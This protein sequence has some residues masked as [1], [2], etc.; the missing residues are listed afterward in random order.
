MRLDEI[1]KEEFVNRLSDPGW[2]LVQ[3]AVRRMKKP[4]DEVGWEVELEYRGA[5]KAYLKLFR[6]PDEGI[7]SAKAHSIVRA[8]LIRNKEFDDYDLEMIQGPLFHQK[9]ISV[10]WTIVWNV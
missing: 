1:S 9:G 8:Y 10:D 4:L 5:G 2:E 6:R 7:P 3:S